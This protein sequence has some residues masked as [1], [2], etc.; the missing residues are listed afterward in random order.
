MP[1][2]IDNFYLELLIERGLLGLALTLLLM[3]CALWR[4]VF[5]QAR[6]HGLAP[7]LAASLSGVM[8]VG[9]VSSVM[10]V[11]RVAFLVFW[12]AFLALQLPGRGHDKPAG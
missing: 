2:H 12:L 11:P 6:G 1:W 3:A 8:V 4:L 7:Y 9:L 10:D 5:G